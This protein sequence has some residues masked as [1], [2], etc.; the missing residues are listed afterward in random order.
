MEWSWDLSSHGQEISY[1]AFVEFGLV[2][3]GSPLVSSVLFPVSRFP[4]PC[5]E[6]T[7][8]KKHLVWLT[9]WE[10]SAPGWLTALLWSCRGGVLW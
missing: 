10:I 9:V 6:S 1:L 5:D 7:G 4:F 2:L 8:M 3:I